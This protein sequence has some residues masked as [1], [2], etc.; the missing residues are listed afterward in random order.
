[1]F[2]VLSRVMR[3]GLRDGSN[4]HRHPA[5]RFLLAALLCLVLLSARQDA[6]AEPERAADRRDPSFRAW[7]FAEGNSR[8][9]FE[10]FFTLLNLSDGPA[11]VT[12]QYNRDDGIRLL[13]GSGSSR[14][15]G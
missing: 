1:M 8:N 10:T 6:R 5:W 7:H 14:A 11:S 2:L 13:H 3:P 12:A 4:A 9:G 15:H